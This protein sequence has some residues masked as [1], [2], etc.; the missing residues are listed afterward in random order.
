M[1]VL[2]ERVFPDPNATVWAAS[3][4]NADTGQ[5]VRFAGDWRMMRDIHVA[6]EQ[7]EEPIA[8]VPDWAVLSI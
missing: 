7:G 2:V 3:G 1:Q 4:I 8:E 6:V 5:P